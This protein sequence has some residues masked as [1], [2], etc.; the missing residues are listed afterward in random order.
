MQKLSEVTAIY[1]RVFVDKLNDVL[2]TMNTRGAATQDA[3][4][5][6]VVATLLFVLILGVLDRLLQ[7]VEQRDQ[8]GAEGQR[9]RMH[10][11][12]YFEAI[13]SSATTVHV[14][15]AL[16]VVGRVVILDYGIG[17]DELVERI[18]E[19]EKPERDKDVVH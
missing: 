9:A 6:L 19:R 15:L 16:F 13:S 1:V 10:E 2:A 4:N 11:Q 12:A 18:C 14:L 5:Y 3:T 7:E 8:Q 17:H